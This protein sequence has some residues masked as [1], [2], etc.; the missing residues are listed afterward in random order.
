MSRAFLEGFWW[1]AISI[2]TPP[3]CAYVPRTVW[4]GAFGATIT[5]SRS[6]RGTTC[7]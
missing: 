6:A 1:I 3:P 4:P 7:P 5:T 2:G